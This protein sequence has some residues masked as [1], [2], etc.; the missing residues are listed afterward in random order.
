MELTKKY[1]ILVIDD[2]EASV[3]IYKRY[4]EGDSYFHEDTHIYSINN[5][6]E[7]KKI[8]KDVNFDVIILDLNLIDSYG[9]STLKSLDTITPIIVVSADATYEV[10][11]DCLQ[12]GAYGYLT[13]PI[14]RHD[15]NN[16]LRLAIDFPYMRRDCN[17]IMLRDLYD[18]EKSRK[19]S[20][21]DH[22]LWTQIKQYL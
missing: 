15:L 22:S 7:G 6:I 10:M 16:R 9:I 11:R 19:T 20:M 4:I 14:N 17:F 2:D 1:N 8:I 12:G 5:I 21:I 3:F 13:K 18:L